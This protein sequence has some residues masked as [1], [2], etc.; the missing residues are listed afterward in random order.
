MN[1]LP[2]DLAPHLSIDVRSERFSRGSGRH[3]CR[4]EVPGATV[5]GGARCRPSIAGCKQEQGRVVSCRARW[6]A[7]ALGRVSIQVCHTKTL[8]TLPSDEHETLVEMIVPYAFLLSKR[9]SSISRFYGDKTML[10]AEHIKFHVLY[11]FPSCTQFEVETKHSSFEAVVS[12]KR[13]SFG[14]YERVGVRVQMSHSDWRRWRKN[15]N[16]TTNID[17]AALSVKVWVNI[18]IH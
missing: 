5:T 15:D 11:A 6:C 12:R 13:E 14:M 2:F 1:A 9:G 18:Y 7:G 3:C 10:S 4:R 16:D 17:F 8:T